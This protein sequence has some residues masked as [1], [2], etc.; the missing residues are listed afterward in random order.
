[1]GS[2]YS[3]VAVTPTTASSAKVDVSYFPHF[4][5]DLADGDRYTVTLS[6]DNGAPLTYEQ[7]VTYTISYPNG[8]ECGRRRR[9]I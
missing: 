1:M 3:G 6:N 5:L 7:T 4:E 2:D 8:P 9:R